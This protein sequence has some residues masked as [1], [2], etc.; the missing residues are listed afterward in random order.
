[1]NALSKPQDLSNEHLDVEA[2]PE[3]YSGD[4]KLLGLGMT[5]CEAEHGRCASVFEYPHLFERLFALGIRGRAISGGDA[6]DALGAEPVVFLPGARFSFARHLL[7]A[8]GYK[9]AVIVPARDTYGEVA[10]LIAVDLDTDTIAAWLSRFDA[11]EARL[12]VRSRLFSETEACH[13]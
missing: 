5:E 6:F 11:C 2:L 13:E 7:D 10:D 3:P 9:L 12:L 4:P 8:T 1:M